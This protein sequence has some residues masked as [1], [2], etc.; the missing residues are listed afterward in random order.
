MEKLTGKKTSGP[1]NERTS[2]RLMF[3]RLEPVDIL[4]HGAD[5]KAKH[6]RVSWRNIARYLVAKWRRFVKYN[7]LK[8]AAL[9]VMAQHMGDCGE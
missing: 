6:H 3:Q 4:E 1:R 8:R 2:P 5:L 9:Y 7:Q